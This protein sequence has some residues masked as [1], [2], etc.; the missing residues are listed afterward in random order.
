MMN[1]IKNHKKEEKDKL[2]SQ[3][4]KKYLEKE[5]LVNQEEKRRSLV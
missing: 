5:I 1:L 4:M 2:K 3:V